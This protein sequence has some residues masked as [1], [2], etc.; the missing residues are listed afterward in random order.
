MTDKQKKSIEILTPEFSMENDTEVHYSGN[1]IGKIVGVDYDGILSEFS[2]FHVWV[3]NPEIKIISASL[4]EL[5]LLI[6]TALIKGYIGVCRKSKWDSFKPSLISDQDQEFTISKTDTSIQLHL[7]IDPVKRVISHDNLLILLE[8]CANF[9]KRFE[10][11]LYDAKRYKH[12]ETIF[13]MSP[14]DCLESSDPS[15]MWDVV[16]NYIML[17]KYLKLA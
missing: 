7:S 4:S 12:Y 9:C 13:E 3:K 6:R 11:C 15:R 10:L 16:P 2:P 5:F 17:L 1:Y 14:I 8:L